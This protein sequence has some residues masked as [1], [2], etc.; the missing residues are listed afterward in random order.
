VTGHGTSSGGKF[1]N[2]GS[3]KQ[4]SN[5]ILIPFEMDPLNTIKLPRLFGDTSGWI[6]PSE[7]EIEAVVVVDRLDEYGRFLSS[8]DFSSLDGNQH[9]LRFLP[10][11]ILEAGGSFV[12][13][14]GGD[15]QLGFTAQLITPQE[16][17]AKNQAKDRNQ[18]DPILPDHGAAPIYL[19]SS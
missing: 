17:T 15:D 4:Q 11:W 8:E 19:F 13:V 6:Y 12:D 14:G 10:D 2:P 7:Q 1:V 16:P 18:T 5:P 9:R 3:L